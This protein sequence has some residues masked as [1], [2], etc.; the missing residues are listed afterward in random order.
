[1]RILTTVVVSLLVFFNRRQFTNA[2][3]PPD[4]KGCAPPC[5]C[6]GLKGE[7]LLPFSKE[8][9]PFAAPSLQLNRLLG[10]VGFMGL[11]GHP[12]EPGDPGDEGPEGMQG[13]IGQQ[14]EPGPVGLKGYRGA[15][16]RTP[17]PAGL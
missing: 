4:C 1:M 3:A 9:E 16:R 13:Q 6:P 12:G 7:R 2:Y 5:I 8:F 10:D 15:Q 17:A 14:G 11:P